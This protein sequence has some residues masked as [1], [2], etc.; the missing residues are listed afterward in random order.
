VPPPRLG[1]RLGRVLLVLETSTA[2][3]VLA[4]AAD[5]AVVASSTARSSSKHED[6]LLPALD[7]L[8]AAASAEKS[9]LRIIAVGVGPGGFTSLRVGI[10]TAKGLALGLRT[11]LVG[12]CSLRTLARGACP[13]EGVVVV[14]QDARRGEVHAAV[15]AIDADGS[16]ALLEPMHGQVG[17]AMKLARAAV[18]LDGRVPVVVGDGARACAAEL[19]AIGVHR[20]APIAFDRPQP[21]AMVVES[22]EAIARDEFAA[23]DALEPLYVKPSEY[24]M[25]AV[26]LRTTLGGE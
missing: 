1:V 12:V 14:V 13:T 15:Y 8:L 23:L 2:E 7:A 22:L 16:R 18:A 24:A 4:L 25:P 10:A 9:A 11:K 21:T 26:K 5:G 17:E 20:L 3:T 19:D 6:T